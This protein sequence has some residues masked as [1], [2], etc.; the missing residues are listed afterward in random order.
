MRKYLAS[1]LVMAGLSASSIALAEA[2]TTGNESWVGLAKLGA[3]IAIGLGTFG[4]A[5]GQGRASSAAMEGIA[6]NPTSRGDVFVPLI[7]ALAFMEF[8][9]LLSFIVALMLVG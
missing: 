3:A 1:S 6:R 4:A 8:Q 9:A 5:T 7:I 2:S